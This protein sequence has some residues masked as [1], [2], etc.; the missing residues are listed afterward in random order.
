MVVRPAGEFSWQ[1]Q[2]QMIWPVKGKIVSTFADSSRAGGGGASHQGVDLAARSGEPVTAAL[3]GEV[4]FVGGIPGYGNVV[5]LTHADHL[6]TVYAHVTEPRV[7]VGEIVSREQTIA[8]VGPEGYIHYEVRESKRAVDPEKLIALAPSPLPGGSVDVSRSLSEE[9]ASVGRLPGVLGS[10]ALVVPPR[11]PE[12][13]PQEAATRSFDP[14]EIPT[15]APEA[16]SSGGRPTSLGLAV[17][18]FGVNL[19]YV[20]AKLVYAGIGALT[21]GV[22]LVLAHDSSVA[23]AIWTPTLGGDYFVAGRHLRGDSS[24]RFF[25]QGAASPDTSPR[26]TSS[27]ETRSPSTR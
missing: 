15:P 1:P 19:L 26:A 23:A 27:A 24:L 16:E 14:A 18:L 22:A 6:T 21:G 2:S 10:A 9:P 17:A 5:A 20:P 3:P 25:G 11:T 7:R 8:L 4:G 12:Q 13:G